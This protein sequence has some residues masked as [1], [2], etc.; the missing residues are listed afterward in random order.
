MFGWYPWEPCSF[1]KRSG[2]GM[3][4]EDKD[5]VGGLLEGNEGGETAQ[6]YYMGED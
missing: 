2:G 4:M 1:L 6:M 5:L 3:D